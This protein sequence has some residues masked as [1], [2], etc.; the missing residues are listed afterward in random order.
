MGHSQGSPKKIQ[1]KVVSIVPNPTTTMGL[2]DGQED[3]THSAEQVVKLCDLG[4]EDH[5]QGLRGSLDLEEF[6]LPDSVVL[7]SPFPGAQ[8][9]DVFVARLRAAEKTTLVEERSTSSDAEVKG[10]KDE[11]NHGGAKASKGR[12]T[13]WRS[14]R[15]VLLDPSSTSGLPV[16]LHPSPTM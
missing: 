15:T 5:R 16:P 4:L 7:S 13:I 12:T 2:V 11:E 10:A 9:F 14:T 6:P 8:A 3:T 1:Q